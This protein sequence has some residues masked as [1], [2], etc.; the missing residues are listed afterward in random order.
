MKRTKPRVGDVVTVAVT[1]YGAGG[2]PIRLGSVSL[3]HDLAWHDV[4]RLHSDQKPHHLHIKGTLSFHSS[5][6]L[7]F[8][9]YLLLQLGLVARAL[10]DP[11]A[12]PLLK[13]NAGLTLNHYIESI[14]LNVLFLN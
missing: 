8:V 14:T 9:S 5:G 2:M 7:F 13:T 3:R 1:S 4:L 11:H 10:H 6:H 12:P